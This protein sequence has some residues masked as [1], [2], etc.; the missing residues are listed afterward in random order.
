MKP[1]YTFLKLIF[2]IFLCNL[3][4]LFGANV[5]AQ[6]CSK[7]TAT[8]KSYESR[9]ASTGSIKI[10]ASG[11]SGSYKYK[12]TGPV[13]TDFTSTDSLTGLSAGSYTIEVKDIT[14]N[15]S[16]TKTNIVVSGS[17]LDPRFTLSGTA[18]TCEGGTNGSISI[19]TLQD[20]RSPFVYSIVAPS[21]MGVGTS[22]STGAFY[23]L[24][25]GDY[26]IR[27]TDSCG[28]IQ[29]R[30]ITIQGY[31]WRI[32]SYVFNKISCDSTK[33]YIKVIDSKGNIS[34]VGEIPGFRYG[35]VRQAG[36]T[37]W[38][39]SANITAYMRG[40]SAFDI[41]VKD[42]C[43]NIKKGNTSISLAPSLGNNINIYGNSCDKF[44]ASVTGITNFFTPSFC[45]YNSNNV[46]VA[47][48]TNGVFTGLSYGNYCIVAKDCCTNTTFSRCF[49]ANPPAL[50]V[51][52][53]AISNKTC[54]Q[55]TASVTGQV[56]LTNPIYSLYSGALV[57]IASN[58]TGIF[59]NL[60]YD[61]Y[62]ITVKDGCRD[63][64]IQRYFSAKRPTPSVSS[65]IT[66]SYVNCTNFGLVITGDSLTTPDFCLYDTL[67]NV[68]ACNTTGIFDSIAL[69]SYCVK[70]HDGCVDTTFLR[71]FNVDKPV[72]TNSVVV[73]QTNTGCNTFTATVSAIGLNNPVYSLYNSADLLLDSN[74][75]GVF[76]NL[77]LGS[78]YVQTKVSCPDTAFTKTF[79]ISAL[80]P[81]VNNTVQ[82]SN[83]SCSAFDA[84]ITSQKNLTS[85]QYC[86]YN[87]SN[88]L[89][90][91]NSTG[92]FT[93]L[94]YGSYCIK[95]TNTCYDTV[96]SRCFTA[97]PL[98]LGLTVNSSKSCTYGASKFD[99]A[100]SGATL[101]VSIKI[102]NSG[103]SLLYNKSFGTTNMTV[104]N[105]TGIIAGQAYKVVATDICGRTNFVN[106]AAVNSF[107]NHMPVAISKCPGG[108]WPDG[109]GKIETTV[110][111]NMGSLSVSI[112]KKDNATL[113]PV[114]GP[115]SV[116]GS[117]YTFDD[118]GPAIYIVKYVANDGCGK[119]VYD[120]VIINPYKFPNLQKSTAYQCDVN[121]F[122][123]GA[124]ATNG[125][126]PYNYEI[127][128][129]YPDNP[130]IIAAP[131]TNPLFNIDNGTKYGLI[132]LRALDA[133]GNGTLGDAS[134]LPLADNKIFS[135]SNCF[136]Q[137]TTLTVDPI[138]NST[139]TWYKK[140]KENSTDSAIVSSG[141]NSM[142]IP[143][144]MPSDTGIYIL[145][146]AVG[147]CVSRTYNYH[148][149]GNCNFSVLPVKSL[150]FSGKVVSEKAQLSWKSISQ[151]NVIMYSIERKNNDNTFSEIGRVK[152]TNIQM[153]YYTDQRTE[154]GNNYYRLKL[155]SV[156]NSFT[157]SNII[158]LATGE[159]TT[160]IRVFPNPVTDYFTVDFKNTDNHVYKITLMNLNN[161]VIR[162]ETLNS[163]LNKKLEM[164]RSKALSNGIYIL[165]ILDTNNNTE[166]NQKI[167]FK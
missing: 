90:N 39:T 71:C 60:S 50:S 29:T 153:Y 115:N 9:C 145:H 30:L 5:K 146:Q 4:S 34:T 110:S 68:I 129:S 42:N 130:S 38:S 111:T 32:D 94:S 18:I 53:V 109:S 141:S 69:G 103:N 126:S 158:T 19:N 47:C 102:Y 136:V 3:F 6:D 7:L 33:G 20:G 80:I 62:S 67:G 91:C 61:N 101:P 127:I 24:I 70:V 138:Y 156:D 11:G 51:G 155:I 159:A 105:V 150:E 132:R 44:S 107:F 26:S 142:Y 148:L 2:S 98:P 35:V 157:Y 72:A 63:T 59:N 144:L 43:G 122:T 143:T 37:A 10:V 140:D 118:L 149:D 97:S 86:L 113:S 17:Y 106:V 147:T 73:K 125:V 1:F 100:T 58:S 22:N 164:K 36:D 8:F 64:T 134:I 27:M 154:N 166:H 151:E 135:S 104:D 16:F 160:E 74:T 65:V 31:S 119:S 121:G 165:R 133:C 77:G 78:Y 167:I 92:V 25:A 131:Q 163:S 81:S 21:P 56:G 79:T 112:I 162:E 93:G 46:Q 137:P 123:V 89:V 45:L 76:T 57:L 128:G 48:N 40:I 108:V 75:S 41:V 12:A 66:P 15:C 116:S 87:N 114:L 49:T 13:N 88:Q 28:G 117:V 14:T 152:A 95:I 120:T 54:T 99:I 85:P 82:L 23:N 55:F 84:S 161:Q 124:V 96:I 139:Y 52:I 83:Y